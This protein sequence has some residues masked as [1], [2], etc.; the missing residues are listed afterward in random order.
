MTPRLRRRVDL[1]FP[2]PGSRSEVARIVAE[3]TDSERAQSAIVLYAAGDLER[4]RYAVRLT[5]ADWRDV[6][7]SA[8]L[9][10]ND[11]REK[12]DGELGSQ[13]RTE[14]RPLLPPSAHVCRVQDHFVMSGSVPAGRRSRSRHRGSR[15]FRSCE[16]LARRA[17][18]CSARLG[19][20]CHPG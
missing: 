18:T 5:I 16:A 3:T 6:L 4:L 8:G 2:S 10:D 19:P 12:L 13:P 7:V 14:K 1:D 15:A 9:A 11:W 17:P 20:G